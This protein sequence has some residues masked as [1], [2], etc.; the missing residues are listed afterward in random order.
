MLIILFPIHNTPKDLAIN[1]GVN[2]DK[3]IVINPGVFPVKEDP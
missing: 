2:G 1:L 3:I